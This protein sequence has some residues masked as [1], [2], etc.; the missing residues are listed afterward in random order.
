[1]VFI[2]KKP[3]FDLIFQIDQNDPK[4]A[5]NDRLAIIRGPEG[6]FWS[7]RPFLRQKHDI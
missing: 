6:Q 5:Q 2:N 7:Y 3:L 1:M 4:W